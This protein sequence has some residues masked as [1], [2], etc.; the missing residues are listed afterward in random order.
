MIRLLAM[1]LVVLTITLQG[2]SDESATA[3]PEAAVISPS[4]VKIQSRPSNNLRAESGLLNFD[5]LSE[6]KRLRALG[7]PSPTQSAYYR[8]LPEEILQARAK[9][10]EKLAKT[11]LVERLASEALTLQNARREDGTFPEG[12]TEE[13]A[14]GGIGQMAFHLGTLTQDPNNAMA[15]YLWGI[16]QAASIYGGPYEP[17]VAG[18]RLAGL[19][20]DHRAI[21]FEREFRAAHPNLDEAD[22]EMYFDSGRRR[23]EMAAIPRG[24]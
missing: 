7:F 20:G 16:T 15:G 22:V 9:S 1:A 11:F 14:V 18:I 8:A 23:M 12:I 24:P 6:D 13:D 5:Y 3:R 2:C 10:G 19:R 4:P 17:I 21:E